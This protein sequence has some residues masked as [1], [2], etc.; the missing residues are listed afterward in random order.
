MATWLE[1]TI[2]DGELIHRFEREA[3]DWPA[4]P[5]VGDRINY[6]SRD[7][8]ALSMEVDRVRWYGDGEVTVSC[9][10]IRH[11]RLAN[12]LPRDGW[13]LRAEPT[14]KVDEL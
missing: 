11:T 6:G 12:D 5:R 13:K 3:P 9:G 4:I 8:E 14:R 2:D 1:V 7:H 10:R